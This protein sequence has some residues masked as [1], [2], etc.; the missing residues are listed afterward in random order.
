MQKISAIGIKRNITMTR[1]LLVATLKMPF[2][3]TLLRNPDLDIGK[4][5][6]KIKSKLST[7]R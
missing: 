3:G 2:P 1:N 7:Y 4:K 5:V 6:I